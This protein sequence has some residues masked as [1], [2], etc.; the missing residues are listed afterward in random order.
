MQVHKPNRRD[1]SLLPEEGELELK[2]G[3]CIVLPECDNI[4]IQTAAKDF[5]EYLFVSMNIVTAVAKKSVAGMQS[6][7]LAVN[8]N[9]EEA[10]GY[11]G[12]RITTNENGILIE[13]WHDKGVAQAL[14]AL[15]D[16]MNMRKAPF[17]EKGVIKR[18]AVFERRFTQSPMGYL[19]YTDEILSLIAHYGMDSI[20]VWVKDLEI[21]LKGDC[22]DLNLICDRAEKYGIDVYLESYIH[23]TK[24]PDDE[25]AEE[26]Y[27]R[28]YG[29]MFAKCPKLK[30]LS[31]S[32]EAQRFHS[33]DPN[34]L[35]PEER[36]FD[37]NLPKTKPNPGG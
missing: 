23:H 33:H 14:Y 8:E 2:N 9:I 16:I 4:V 35:T 34:A 7:T 18:K 5:A 1:N 25:G 12:Y 11:M 27:D 24:H 30:G 10:S 3:I 20:L 37:D 17:V 15:E 22:Y 19:Q 28:L 6:V 31:M 32:G 13:G 21:D 36:A 29:K 26:Y